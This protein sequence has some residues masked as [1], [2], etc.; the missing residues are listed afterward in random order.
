MGIPSGHSQGM[1]RNRDL[2]SSKLERTL[3]LLSPKSHRKESRS[4]R[5]NPAT[6][7]VSGFHDVIVEAFEDKLVLDLFISGIIPQVIELVRVILQVEKFTEIVSVINGK[8]VSPG[9]IHRGEGSIAIAELLVERIE[10]LGTNAVAMM[11]RLALSGEDPSQGIA[12]E[13]L[14]AL[15]SGKIKNRSTHIE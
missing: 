5:S 2:L 7:N 9:P 14:R 10:V 15:D 4:H 8:L 12:L 1:R 13:I 11:P 6:S 3:S